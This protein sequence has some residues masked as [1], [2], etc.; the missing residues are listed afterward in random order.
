[1]LKVVCIFTDIAFS[2]DSVC[3]PLMYFCVAGKAKIRH[4]LQINSRLMY[5]DIELVE[6]EPTVW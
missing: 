2:C 1:M 5:P 6:D 4:K 3:G